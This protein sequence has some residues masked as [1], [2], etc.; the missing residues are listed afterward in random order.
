MKVFISGK[1]TNDNNYQEHFAKVE[2]MLKQLGHIPLNPAYLPQG[3]TDAEYMSIGFRMLE[4]CDAICLLNNW[5][6]S[7]GAK[8]EY[9]YANYLSKIIFTETECMVATM[10]AN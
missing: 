3:M 6:D 1:I 2:M 10:E 7:K 5:R 9:E 8:L 4:C